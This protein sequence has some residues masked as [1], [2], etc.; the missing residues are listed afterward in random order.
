MASGADTGPEP[1]PGRVAEVC[2]RAA[3]L[4]PSAPAHG[5][6]AC[7]GLPSV[8]VRLMTCVSDA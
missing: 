5:G 8:L 6:D 3:A 2:N 4:P 1:Q 7:L